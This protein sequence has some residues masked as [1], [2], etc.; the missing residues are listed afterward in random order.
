MS[1][2]EDWPA[3]S[4]PVGVFD[5]LV[6]LDRVASTQDVA[7]SMIADGPGLAVVARRQD[8]GRGRQGRRW[9]DDKG[10]SLTLS[11]IVAGTLPPAGLSLA[12]GLAVID[13]CRRLGVAGLGLKWPND[14]VERCTPASEG[15]RRPGADEGDIGGPVGRK[16]AG[17]L[18][19]AVDGLAIVGIGLNVA[20][21]DHDWPQELAGRAVSL[22]QL[23][24][25]CDRPSACR[26]VLEALSRWVSAP[27]EAVRARWSQ[28]G[29]MRGRRCRV[30]VG[31]R[32]I[33][34]VAVGLDERWRLVLDVGQGR[35]VGVE[36]AHAHVEE[37]AVTG[38]SH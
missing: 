2:G 19:E 14:V 27:G 15:Q 6:V 30:V 20:Q 22:A 12:A 13:A 23:G 31:D 3:L 8:A 9:L 21:R 33:E 38:G 11:A 32:R 25:A 17:V 26:A 18:I 34:G 37:I 5:R 16:V 28:A 29:T 1:V 10:L 7:R 35:R 36:A 24:A 4:M